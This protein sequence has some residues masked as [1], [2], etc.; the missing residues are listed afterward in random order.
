MTFALAQEALKIREKSRT[1]I[2]MGH[3]WDHTPNDLS[4]ISAYYMNMFETAHEHSRKALDYS[5]DNERLK[6]NLKII[7]TK[8]T[9]MES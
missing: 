9:I 3:S 5:P 8:V 1:F 6:N 7:G 4:A 2:N